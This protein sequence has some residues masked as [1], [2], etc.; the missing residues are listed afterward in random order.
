MPL[1]DQPL[2]GPTVRLDPTSLED[3]AGLLAAATSPET[4][5]WFTRLPTPFDRSGMERYL[6]LLIDDTSVEPLTLRLVATNEV[7]GMTSYLDI[8]PEHRTLE[9]GWTFIAPAHRG[10]RTNPE[11]K[12]L[13]LAHAFEQPIFAPCARH[14]GGPALRVCLKTHHRN[15]PSQRA[16]AKLGAVYEG[17]LRNL[18][19]MPDGS[20]R[21]SVFY[22]VIAHEWPG[23]RDGLDRRLA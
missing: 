1:V 21:H 18:V 8:R 5:R 22:S 11:M 20:N 19:I 10:T 4:F 16:M 13:L 17:T 15:T 23:V 14:T 9:I 12:R 7:V 3:A 6:Q 2:I